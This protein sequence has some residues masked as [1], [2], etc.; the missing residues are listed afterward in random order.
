LIDFNG[1][2]AFS[3]CVCRLFYSCAVSRSDV[4][5]PVFL[6]PSWSGLTILFHRCQFFVAGFPA[7]LKE[8]ATGQLFLA[9]NPSGARPELVSH[10]Q[11]FVS[12]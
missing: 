3:S 11:I 10:C 7:R 1:D 5:V 6:F 12:A 8:R 4:F 9:W 2:L